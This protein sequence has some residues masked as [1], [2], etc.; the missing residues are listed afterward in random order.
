MKTIALRPQRLRRQPRRHPELDDMYKLHLILKYL[1]KRRIAWVSLIAVM[2]CTAMVIVVISVMG[3]WLRMF[4]E[5]A[6]GIAGDIIIS[7]QS[8][9]GYPFYQEMIERIDKIDGVQDSVPMIHTF[10]LVNIANQIQ[11]GVEVVGLPIEK[12][13]RVNKLRQSLYR[14][15]TCAD[16]PDA[17]PWLRDES[18]KLR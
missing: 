15:W 12:I 6:H 11:Y 7:R 8:L 16:D 13:E 4:R 10:G 14:Q 17:P 9:A 3:G 1:R 18:R 5:S 2:L